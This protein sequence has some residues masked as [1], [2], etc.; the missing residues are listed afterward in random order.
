MSTPSLEQPLPS[1][2]STGKCP[3]LKCIVKGSKMSNHVLSWYRQTEGNGIEFLV[4]AGIRIT[5]LMEKAL[6]KDWSLSLKS[7]QIPSLW[8][9]GMQKRVM[10]ACT[11]VQCG[12]PTSTS[13]DKAQRSRCRA[14]EHFFSWF[15]LWSTLNNVINIPFSY[16]YCFFISN[17]SKECTWSQQ[18]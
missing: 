17:N 8:L 3:T 11:T 1:I 13:L 6:Q 7:L 5:Q 12:T 18:G 10:R 16:L 2:T 4:S 9:S 15:S 14:G